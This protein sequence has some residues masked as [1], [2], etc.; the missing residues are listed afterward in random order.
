MPKGKYTIIYEGN[1]I[2]LA[3]DCLNVLEL[4]GNTAEAIAFR[5]TIE[6]GTVKVVAELIGTLRRIIA[7]TPHSMCS[8]SEAWCDAEA[9]LSL[10]GA[11]PALAF[12]GGVPC[13]ECCA[14]RQRGGIHECDCPARAHRELVR[15]ARAVRG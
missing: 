7:A 4:A 12:P 6:G 9:F 15:I 14:T 10:C 1:G 8:D 3:A 11:D 2:Q 13:Y 5:D